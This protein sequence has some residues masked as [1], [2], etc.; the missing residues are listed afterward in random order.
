MSIKETIQDK[1]PVFALAAAILVLGFAF[2]FGPPLV[3]WG[4]Y[5]LWGETGLKIA[6]W[7]MI[8]LFLGAII[9]LIVFAYRNKNFQKGVHEGRQIERPVAFREGMS[10]GRDETLSTVSMGPVVFRNLATG[11]YT[12]LSLAAYGDNNKMVAVILCGDS[13]F[14]ERMVLIPREFIERAAQGM[15]LRQSY[16]YEFTRDGEEWAFE[17]SY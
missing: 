10:R 8:A 15:G 1:W 5:E 9:T 4:I 12:V 17:F 7:T 13:K 6:Y 14:G 16:T 11:R 2:F 3:G